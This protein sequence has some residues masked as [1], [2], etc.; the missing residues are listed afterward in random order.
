[1]Q[2]DF[3]LSEFS[4]GCKFLLNCLLFALNFAKLSQALS[5]LC[6]GDFTLSELSTR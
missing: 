3:A 2:G 5:E 1:M 6:T 4:T